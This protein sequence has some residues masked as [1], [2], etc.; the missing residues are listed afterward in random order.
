MSLLS[1]MLPWIFMMG[2]CTCLRTNPL[3]PL[4]PMGDS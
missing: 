4:N 1:L 2:H 3:Q